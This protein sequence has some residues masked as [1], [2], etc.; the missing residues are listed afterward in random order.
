MELTENTINENYLAWIDKLK[1]YGCY[2]DSLIDNFGE[3]IR[4]ASYS[5]SV[6]SGG[7]RGTLLSVV[8]YKLCKYAYLYNESL[9]SSKLLYTAPDSL[10][11]PLLLQHISKAL[12]FIPETNSYQIKNGNLFKWND[13]YS[14]IRKT[15][16]RSRRMLLESGIILS[17]EEEFALTI[18]DMEGFDAKS[19]T[20]YFSPLWEIVL[21]ANNMTNIELRLEYNEWIKL[22]QAR[23]Q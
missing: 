8:L 22:Q 16:D 12:M 9:K 23:F 14:S 4:I 18:I 2:S 1:K 21:E 11:K 20:R 13:E 19:K 5:K 10:M 17:D 15:G 6:S 7:G 3:K